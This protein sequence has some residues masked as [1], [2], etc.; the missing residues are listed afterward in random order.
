MIIIHI[1][2]YGIVMIRS[3]KLTF[4]TF[5]LLVSTIY[6]DTVL[7]Q[8]EIPWWNDKWSYREEIIPPIDTTDSHA[9]FQPIDIRITPNN[10]CWI[11]NETIYS[12]RICCWDGQEWYELESQLYDI[13]HK[14]ENLAEAFSLVFLIP[15]FADGNEKYYVYYDEEETPIPEYPDHVELTKD[16][17]YYEPIPGQ[18]AD[19]DYFKITDEDY[20]I[21]GVGISGMMMTEYASQMIFRQS[22]GQKEFDYQL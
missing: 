2:E 17:Y 14:R 8:Q 3:R 20:C 16:H 22:K 15:D 9:Q 21:Y 1:I 11:K 12:V 4:L 6:F 19:F 10:R 7:P 5:F 18:K 13:E